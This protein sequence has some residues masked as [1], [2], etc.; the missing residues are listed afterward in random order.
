VEPAA[1][2]SRGKEPKTK[3]IKKEPRARKCR[4]GE[5]TPSLTAIPSCTDLPEN[6]QLM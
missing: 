5:Q 4:K 3:A 1:K 6:V 2:K